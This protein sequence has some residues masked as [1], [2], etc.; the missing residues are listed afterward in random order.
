MVQNTGSVDGLETKHLVIEVTDE[1]TLCCEGVG[2]DIN[3]GAGDV[4]EETRLSDVGVTADEESAG[5]GVDGGKTTQVLANLL[6]V[7][8]RVLQTLADGGHATE[9]STLELLALEER[10][11][12][13][14]ETDIITGDCLDQVLSGGQLTEGD[15]EVVCIVEGVEQILVEGVDVGETRETIEDGLDFF[16]KGFAGELDLAHVKRCGWCQSFVLIV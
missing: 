12:V 1:Q 8:E 11:T 6:E 4:L 10:L 2:L 7:E 5:V 15:A 14:D 13:L 9:S 16:G 3:I